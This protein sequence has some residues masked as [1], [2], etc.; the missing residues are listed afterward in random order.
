ME[1]IKDKFAVVNKQYATAVYGALQ[2]RWTRAD[3][4]LVSAGI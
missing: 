3:G 4:G 2:N 1:K